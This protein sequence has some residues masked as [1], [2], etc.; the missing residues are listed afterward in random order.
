MMLIAFSRE[1]NTA[2]IWY[3]V[4]ANGTS[5]N[6]SRS[7][8]S[9]GFY[10]ILAVRQD[11]GVPPGT[12]AVRLYKNNNILAGSSLVNIPRNV[13][14]ND[15]YIGHDSWNFG[16]TDAEIAE[17]II[18]NNLI[19]NAQRII[20]ANYLSSKYNIAIFNP[21]DRYSYDASYGNDV[22]GIGTG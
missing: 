12:S 20:I 14:R 10:Q 19:N 9:D 15:N 11:P 18:Y 22:A 5:S 7:S 8:I 13:L 1:D 4:V 16:D 3:Q 21:S 6:I 17:I 2:N